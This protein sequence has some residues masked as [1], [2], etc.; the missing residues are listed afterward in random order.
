M[1]TLQICRDHPFR[2]VCANLQDAVTLGPMAT[3]R[4]QRIAAELRTLRGTRTSTDVQQALGITPSKLSR[5]E[6]CAVRPKPADVR[7]LAEF[8][9]APPETVERLVNA[10][11]QARKP[12]WWAPF[13]GPDWDEAL[14][15]HLEL[16]TEAERIDSWTLD[17]VP[18]LLQVPSYIAALIGGRPDVDEDQLER[19]LELRAARRARVEHGELEVW[20]V[21]SEAALHQEIGGQAVLAEQLSYLS[22]VPG[23][24]TVQVVPF[25]AG[26]HAGLGSP[27]HVLRFSAWPTVVYQETIT[28]GLYRDD[29]EVVEAHARTMDH[30]RAAALSAKESRELLARRVSELEG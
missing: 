29:A 17:L 27:F 28:K 21:L 18:G 11:Q 9:G 26:A 6:S 4:E 30:I 8:Y 12:S 19:R 24:V 5:I 23:R 22:E 13:I 15:H 7:Q 16:E 3:M 10:A 25:N 14:T 2:L 20:A 1:H